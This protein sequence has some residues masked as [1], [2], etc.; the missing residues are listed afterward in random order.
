MD[1]IANDRRQP[2]PYPRVSMPS[3]PALVAGI[4]VAIVAGLAYL[5]SGALAVFVIALI[6]AVILDPVVTRIAMRGVRRSLAAAGVVL[7]LTSATAIVG[8]VAVLAVASEAATFVRA[9]PAWVDGLMGSYRQAPLPAEMR[10]VMDAV[11]TD[12]ASS[13]AEADL[14]GAALD[15]A[16]HALELIA[17]IFGLLPFFLFYV[18]SSRPRTVGGLIHAIPARWRGDVVAVG[19]IA[20]RSLA[21][22]LRGEAILI[23]LLSIL[24]W[25]GLQLVSASVDPRIGEFALFL[26]L[27]AGFSELIP[28]V[29]P[30]IGAAPAIAFALTLG[31]EA[32]FAVAAL[33]L[34][35]AIIEGQILVPL[36]QGRQFAI[37][38]AAIGVAM[39]IGTTLAGLLGAIIALPVLAA[40]LET[41]RYVFRR[42][43]G[44]EAA[45]TIDEPL[46][47]AWH[48][49][50]NSGAPAA[51]SDSAPR[52]FADGGVS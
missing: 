40:G 22:Y 42:A 11:I 48:R 23:A 5:A 32:T 1:G 24:T 38:P 6:L 9:I 15:V 43:T 45:P 13:L 47:T 50:A 51:S 28:I 49:V 34:I 36:V 19:R 31:P 27:I 35:I 26:T 30:W 4:G 52:R 46:H 17:V 20:L 18:L 25:V 44:E 41:Y 2:A 7:G 37:H 21:A 8:I 3:R 39:V 16:S 29:G 10:A 33:Y 12:G 14:A